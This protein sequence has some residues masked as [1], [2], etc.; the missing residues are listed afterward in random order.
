MPRDVGADGMQQQQPAWREAAPGHLEETGIVLVT[1]VLEHADREDRI[2]RLV[3]FAVVLQ[4]DLD[5]QPDAQ[6]TGE[7]GLLFRDGHA[8]AADTVALGRELQCLPPTAAD[9]QHALART[10][11]QLAADQ[12]Q[13]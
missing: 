2:E 13:L 7:L 1:D 10:Q 11:A 9:V 4:A 12:P 8:D 6:L 5:R 3:Q